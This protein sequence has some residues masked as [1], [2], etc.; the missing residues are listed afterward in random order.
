MRASGRKSGPSRRL[1]AGAIS[2][3]LL[4]GSGFRVTPSR[5]PD[6]KQ[7]LQLG[8]WRCLPGQNPEFG[9]RGALQE[10][11]EGA[12]APDLAKIE[13]LVLSAGGTWFRRNCIKSDAMERHRKINTSHTGEELRIEALI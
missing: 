1:A 8:R 13:L 4:C 7:S 2:P 9:R 11:L 6:L 12:I 5:A 3:P 10:L